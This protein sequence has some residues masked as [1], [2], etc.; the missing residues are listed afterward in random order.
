LNLI[1]PGLGA[2]DGAEK[3]YDVSPAIH[4]SVTSALEQLNLLY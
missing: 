1:T 2:S 4:H 3:T